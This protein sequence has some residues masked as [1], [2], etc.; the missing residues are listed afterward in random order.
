MMF[1][2]RAQNQEPCCTAALR[3]ALAPMALLLTG[4]PTASL[5][6]LTQDEFMA[7]N[8]HFVSTMS[9]LVAQHGAKLE[10]VTNWESSNN[11]AMATR[12]GDR[13]TWFIK[14]W[15]G[16]AKWPSATPDS[17]TL[18]LCHELGHHLGGYPFYAHDGAEWASAE[19]QADY[20]STQAC[21]R[22]LWARDTEINA[23]FAQLSGTGCERAFETT[24]EHNLCKRVFS[25]V[26]TNADYMGHIAGG[27]PSIFE[28]DTS[29][30]R[31]LVVAHPR[32][33][34]RVDSK[35]HGLLCAVPFDFAIIPGRA[36]P[37]G[38]NTIGA[39][40]AARLTSCFEDETSPSF[41]HRP[42]CWFHQATL[43]EAPPESDRW[44]AHRNRTGHPCGL[45]IEGDQ[46]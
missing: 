36:Y 24:A 4:Y 12:S 29:R 11:L 41:A 45:N 2:N 13:K 28:R 18:T 32:G 8:A 39:E 46:P 37:S 31:E 38:Q 35:R 1:A 22:M 7:V 20:W 34:C 25:A 23:R 15:G 3:L 33:Q 9:G 30:V 26:A 16:S 43:E 21:T 17:Y 19:G 42:A 6:A 10:L 14:I 40:Q 5:A 44:T 27:R